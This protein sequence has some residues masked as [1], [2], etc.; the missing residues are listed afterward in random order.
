MGPDV[1]LAYEHRGRVGAQWAQRHSGA[2]W[3]CLGLLGHTGTTG[4]QVH[5]H[6]QATQEG[7]SPWATQRHPAGATGHTCT[8]PQGHRRRHT[9]T[10][11]HSH[12]DTQPQRHRDTGTQ[13]HRDTEAQRHRDT[14]TQRHRDTETR[15]HGDTQ[16]D[17]DRGT[18]GGG[19]HLV[20]Y[21][22][23]VTVGDLG[24]WPFQSTCGLVAMTSASHAE[25]RHFDPGQVYASSRTDSTAQVV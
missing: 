20:P 4:T 13:G 10:E 15:R 21:P 8:R 3:V 6:P 24:F 11:T 17:T 14:E 7:G 9:A 16:T 5:R 18:V 2:Q 1:Q 19:Q 23:R 25:G 12:R 22:P